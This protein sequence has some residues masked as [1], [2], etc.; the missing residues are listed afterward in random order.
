MRPWLPRS[1]RDFHADFD[2]VGQLHGCQVDVRGVDLTRIGGSLP[3]S[4]QRFDAGP[5]VP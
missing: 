3:C 2:S 5:R 1:Q 4:F